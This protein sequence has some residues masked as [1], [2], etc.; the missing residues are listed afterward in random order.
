MKP[1]A[2]VRAFNSGPMMRATHIF[3]DM[4]RCVFIDGHG[5]LHQRFH[6]LS[7]LSPFS[8]ALAPRSLWPDS[9]NLDVVEAER[10]QRVAEAEKKTARKAA[11][12]AARKARHSKRLK[13]RINA[14]A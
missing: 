3:E 12:K 6:Y 11:K 5:Q 8:L 2:M 4:A 14:A 7:E 10:E 1:G 9:R 13:G